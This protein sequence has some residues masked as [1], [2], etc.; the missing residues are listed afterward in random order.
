M[1]HAEADRVEERGTRSESRARALLRRGLLSYL[2]GCAVGCVSAPEIY[3]LPDPYHMDRELS[4]EVEGPQIEVGRPNWLLDG[5]SHH[6]LSLPTKLILLNRQALDHRLP[7]ENRR[8]LER[9]LA[10]NGMRTVKVRHNQYDPAGELRRLLRNREVGVLYRASFGFASWLQ[11]T[12]LPDRLL[13]GTPLGTGDHFNPYTNTI[14]TYSSD[15]TILLHEAGHAKDYMQREGRGTWSLLRVLP[16]IDLVEE[17]YASDDAIRFLQCID[18]RPNELR[19]YR[20]LIPAYSTYVS[21]YLGAGA[22]AVLPV[23]LTGHVVGRV[24]ART[25]EHALRA[26][27]SGEMPDLLLRRPFQPKGCRSEE[28][29]VPEGASPDAD[30]TRTEGSSGSGEKMR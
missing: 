1:V 3:E 20:T 16:G 2:L 19:A 13:A 18:D 26:E 15:V 9:Y 7:E 22:I 25:R 12:L 24:Q 11:Y 5:L 6:V 10:L 8:I 27:Q 30:P 23:V 14:N 29:T 17:S 28:T 21:G 4:A